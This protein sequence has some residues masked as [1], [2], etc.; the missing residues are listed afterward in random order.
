M[1]KLPFTLQT[2]V[3]VVANDA[4]AAN[5]IF[6]WLKEWTVLGLLNQFEFRLVL[7]GPAKSIWF[8][9]PVKLPNVEIH[10]EFSSAL[11][12][13]KTL[14][15]GTGWASDLEH[16]ARKFA[17]LN[18]IY[19]VAVIDH[20]V[21]YKERFERVG[22]VVL[23]NTIFVADAYASSLAKYH[24][25]EIDVIELNNTYL[26]EM[27]RS[28]KPIKNDSRNL[29]YVLEPI[30]IDWG[31]EKPGEFQALDYFVENINL[32]TDNEEVNIILRPHPSDQ[33]G[34]YTNWLNANTHLKIQLDSSKSI[35]ESI[36]NA[37]WVVGAETF[38]MVI[39]IATQRNVWCSLPPWAHHCRLPHNSIRHIRF[40]NRK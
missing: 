28:I 37:K 30:R 21:N 25:K 4:G 38:A 13:A 29:L 18:K 32:I 1:S 3:V 36:S 20:W 40:Q 19:S 9:L 31:F 7:D 22:E 23:P 39:G 15:S 11:V 27:V 17:Q 12:E 34:K 5:L 33:P 2:P 14:I 10:S 24:F 35:N 6:A 26:S 16:N 8:A